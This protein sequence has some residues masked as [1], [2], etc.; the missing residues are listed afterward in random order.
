MGCTLARVGAV[1]RL[2][3]GD[4]RLEGK[5]GRLRLMEKG[6]KEKLV[7][8]SGEAISRRDILRAVK[9]RCNAVG[10]SDAFCNHTFRGSGM[11]VFLNNGGSLE[12]AQEMARSQSRYSPL[13]R[14]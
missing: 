10:L 13:H 12:A 2:A 11:T 1:V 8:L 14:P 3:L 9:Q 6:N 7:W 4:Y 5:C